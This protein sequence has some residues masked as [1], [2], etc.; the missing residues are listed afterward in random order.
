MET[1]VDGRVSNEILIGERLREARLDKNLTIDGLQQK[2]KI[3]KRYLEALE[4]GQ[5]EAL[6]GEFYIR[7]FIK[8]YAAAVDLDGE[9][10]VHLY[11]GQLPPET[12][13]PQRE[14]L[15]TIQGSRKAQHV[16]ERQKKTWMDFLPMIL[17]GLV[18]MTV[19]SV[20]FYMTWSDRKASPAINQ[21][22]SSVAVDNQ[23]SSVSSEATKA[24]T[25]ES[26]KQST[27]ESKK[28]ET[29]AMKIERVTSTQAQA[30]I[31]I[32][33]AK[34]PLTLTFKGKGG[35]CW[36][37]VMINN[38]YAYQYTFEDG[39]TQEFALPEGT[40]TAT[41]ILG[42]SEYIEVQANKKAIDFNDPKF[43]ALQ[44]N[45]VLNISYL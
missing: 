17:L 15:Q 8:Q 32:T 37:G 38:D 45:V 42:A 18:A 24:S 26:T 6:P 35:R 11:E 12:V 43:E 4:A 14:Q 34:A 10:L 33:K 25:K 5:F 21:T 40:S 36:V 9:H 27:T 39:V 7:S 16:A 28:Q 31:N 20:V 13:M 30:T 29:D 22:S 44:K 3:Q 19:L 23:V 1:G 41:L 2:T